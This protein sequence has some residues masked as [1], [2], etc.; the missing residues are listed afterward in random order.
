[1]HLAVGDRF[2]EIDIAVSD[3][4]VESALRVAADPCLIVDGGTLTA[5]IG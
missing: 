2:V 5:E 4:N 1:V 3:L